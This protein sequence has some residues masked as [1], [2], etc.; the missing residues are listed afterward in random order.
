MYAKLHFSRGKDLSLAV[1]DI[2]LENICTHRYSWK[3]YQVLYLS[4]QGQIQGFLKWGS[5]KSNCMVLHALEN[6]C[7]TTHNAK[8][9]Y[10]KNCFDQ[11]VNMVLLHDTMEM[12]GKIHI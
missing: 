10:E 3:F 8:F 7:M 1:H 9:I 6:I 4:L 11:I 5:R 2:L 12:L